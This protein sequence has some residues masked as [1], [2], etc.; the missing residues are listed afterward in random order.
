MYIAILICVPFLCNF[1]LGMERFCNIPVIG[2]EIVWLQFYGNYIGAAVT[3]IGALSICILTI[4]DSRHTQ[5][6]NLVHSEITK[7]EYELASRFERYHPDEIINFAYIARIPNKVEKQ[8]EIMRLQTL[9]D[10]YEGMIYSAK[11]IHALNPNNPSR[12]NDVFLTEY[13]DMLNESIAQVNELT[14][15]YRSSSFPQ[16]YSQKIMAIQK[17][18]IKLISRKE[19]VFHYALDYFMS[20]KRE[21]NYQQ[22]LI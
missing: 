4:E 17:E 9:Y 10:T 20:L 2:D 7:L 15:L 8:K 3:T 22:E 5:S 14:N 16:S 6:I 18:N 12:E 19:K 21:L 13:E 1:I 11:F